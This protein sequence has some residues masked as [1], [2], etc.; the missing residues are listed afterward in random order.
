[1]A[2]GPELSE[3]RFKEEPGIAWGRVALAWVAGIAVRAVLVVVTYVLFFMCFGYDW[4][5][6]WKYLVFVPGA[7]ARSY[8]KTRIV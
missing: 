6:F 3:H 5:G 4:P 8:F 2:G 1:M 7:M